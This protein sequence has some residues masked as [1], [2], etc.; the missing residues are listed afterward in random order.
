MI[1]ESAFRVACADGE[2]EEEE[3][4]MLQAIANAL[5]INKRV[6]ELE[7]SIFKRNLVAK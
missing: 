7:I 4:Q 6:L 3:E 1:L 2:V 5:D